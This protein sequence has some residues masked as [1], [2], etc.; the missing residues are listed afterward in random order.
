MS[1]AF[2][3]KS[4]KTLYPHG[5]VLILLVTFSTWSAWNAPN[6]IAA[7]TSN[8]QLLCFS[9]DM[10]Y[11]VKHTSYLT[12]FSAITSY[13]FLIFLLVFTMFEIP[14]QWLTSSGCTI[15]QTTTKTVRKIMQDT[16]YY[17]VLLHFQQHIQT[18]FNSR[19]FQ[20]I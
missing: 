12:I 15:M 1:P 6:F 17:C 10:S 16:F 13:V 3:E 18:S 19:W 8:V 20:H 9:L 14:L 11:W 5:N 4:R 2:H 7:Y